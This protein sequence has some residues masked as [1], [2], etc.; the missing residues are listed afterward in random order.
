MARILTILILALAV[1][2][3][4]V[5]VQYDPYV[6]YKN[7]YDNW[8]TTEALADRYVCHGG[9]VICTVFIGRYTCTCGSP[10]F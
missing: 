9:Q 4:T 8:V 1:G 7:R 5:S 6:I 2:C 3:S 10:L